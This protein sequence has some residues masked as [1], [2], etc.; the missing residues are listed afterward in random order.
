MKHKSIT[1]R[2]LGIFL[3][4]VLCIWLLPCFAL[5]DAGDPPAHSKTA[6]PNEDGTIT[7]SLDVTGDA[8]VKNVDVD[9][10]ANVIIA[11]D[12]SQSMTE[13]S[14][15]STRADQAEAVVYSFVHDLFSYQS[16]SDPTNIQVSLVTFA[17][18]ANTPVTWSS[19]ESD[20]TAYFDSNA[21]DGNV[22]LTYT[23]TTNYG[24]NWQ[25]ALSAAST[26]IGDHPDDTDPTY[27]IL[28]TDGAPT[29]SGNGGNA[30]APSTN[31]G[32]LRPFYEAAL[33]PAGSI[34]GANATLYGIYAYGA[35]NSD[36]LDDVIY[37]A[38]NGTER[39][40]V[41]L[42]TNSNGI[43]D[44]Y[45]NATNADDLQAAID[46]IFSQIVGALGINS[47]AMS[48]GTT[49]EV[50]T[51][52]GVVNLLSVDESSYQYWLTFPL[53]D[54]VLT[55]T[56]PD[57]GAVITYSLTDNGDGTITID[58]TAGGEAK[59]VTVNGE[60]STDSLKY[61]WEEA[62]A[63]YNYDPPEAKLEN[64]AVDWDLSPVGTLLDGVTYT[65]T[66]VC[67]P[68]QDA[69]DMI[70]ALK[71][72]EAY[73]DVVPEEA[74]QYLDENGN[75]T[76]NTTA[77]LSYKDSRLTTDP[78]P[79]EFTNPDAVET[80][81]QSIDIQKEWIGK[82]WNQELN[83]GE[84]AYENEQPAVLELYRDG[85]F[86]DTITLT[87]DG[88][89]KISTYIAIGL[90]TV[91]KDKGTVNVLT[92][93]HDFELKETG[94]LSYHWELQSDVMHPMN[95][96][97][98]LTMLILLDEADVPADVTASDKDYVEVDGTAYYRIKD[99]DTAK[100]YTANEDST[101]LLA[102]NVRRS[103]LNL[104]KEVEGTAVP[105]DAE[106]TYDIDIMLPDNVTDAKEKDLYFSLW[107]PDASAY[108]EE[109]GKITD[110][111]IYLFFDN[112][113]EQEMIDGEWTGYY[114]ASAD[115]T[116]TVTIPAGINL[117]FT[118]VLTGTGFTIVETPIPENFE[119]SDITITPEEDENTPEDLLPVIGVEDA[120]ISGT[121]IQGNVNYQV[122]F[123]NEYQLTEAVIEKTFSGITPDL[124]PADF[125]IDVSYG[126][127]EGAVEK[128]LSIE[129]EDVVVSEDELTYTWTIGELPAN[130]EVTATENPGSDV[131]G[132]I[133]EADE[134]LTKTATTSLTDEA[135]IS[136]TNTY[137]PD[138]NTGTLTITKTFVGLTEDLIP[139]DFTITVEGE[140]GD[141]YTLK[142]ANDEGDTDADTDTDTDTDT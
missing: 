22:A 43:E 85:E 4:V 106:F 72:G 84:G 57:S 27:V 14:G 123:T 105:E 142:L 108:T 13:T 140:G 60:L 103:T 122:T 81:A 127:G 112:S 61:Q 100:Y 59:S 110:D 47:V 68:G 23:N 136:F 83:D 67:A 53:T 89:Y 86:F 121:V 7:L 96:N 30:I 3:A 49:S 52:T 133:L 116:I 138:E 92:K 51:S 132:Y 73:E 8:E 16:T 126:E 75:L 98:T 115:D 24:T 19:T 107:A 17:T 114:H 1:K 131:E 55:M 12:V 62:N 9:G 31:L 125:A 76:T 29:A 135:K 15:S 87:K 50:T 90:M 69:Y 40:P 28:I 117:R 38:Y 18:S 130:T 63:F 26:L 71:N 21:T 79:V 94:D 35:A 111:G 97:G 48:D 80:T 91:N 32:T 128:T 2:V 134:E 82:Y 66:F 104:I 44:Y 45:F 64:S 77:T 88:G 37:Y 6:T 42:A 102:T 78:E 10:R 129:D 113:G 95:V 137:T 58:W 119:C 118:N 101:S 141:T 11:Y 25:S 36:L 109:D 33:P 46:S 120:T 56:N 5:A 54:N 99:G 93:G 34:T 139:G 20:V 70:A 41:A 74:R 65:V 39:D 124:I